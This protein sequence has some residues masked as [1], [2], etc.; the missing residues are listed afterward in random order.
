MNVGRVLRG[1][2]SLGSRP[3]FRRAPVRTLARVAYWRVRTLA[4]GSVTI[5]LPAF[6]TSISVPA[7]WR[8]PPKILFMFGADYEPELR[9]LGRL[10]EPGDTFLDVGAS[11]GMYSVVAASI[12]GPTGRVVAI[13]ADEA[14]V[15]VLSGNLERFDVPSH[16]F[17]GAASDR[18]QQLSFF[19]DAD[20]S[21]SGLSAYQEGTAA[22]TV[23]A[24]RIDD[25]LGS[26]GVD[27][28]DAVKLDIEGAEEVALRGALDML[29]SS[30]P[31]VIF[32]ANCLAAERLGLERN[33]AWELL[34]GEGYQFRRFTAKGEL[35]VVTAPP[36][37]FCNVVA[38]WPPG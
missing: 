3:E 25:V 6:G 12:V 4:G 34:A 36:D 7:E 8:G 16:P 27:K 5:R 19:V 11:Y 22:C 30:H 24:H 37:D 13:E 31:T 2:Q 29:R 14:S 10:L 18:R 17:L 20:V 32:E 28:V 1:V 35:E 33:G 26:L 21:R 38:V 23:E 15:E 9:H